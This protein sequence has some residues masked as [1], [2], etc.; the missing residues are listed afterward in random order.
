MASSRSLACLCLVFGLL[1]S[2]VSF[3]PILRHLHSPRPG[4]GYVA[5]AFP[6]TDGPPLVLT[7]ATLDGKHRYNMILGL[8]DRTY[9]P[10]T[11]ANVAIEVPPGE[12]CLAGWMTYG[13]SEKG[14]LQSPIPP[15]DALGRAFRVE[16]ATVVFL[17]NFLLVS[18]RTREKGRI[19]YEYAFT[20]RKVP[21]ERMRSD[22][23]QSYPG[24]ADL[25]FNC[26]F[27]DL[28][29]IPEL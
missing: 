17:G 4:V 28:K 2:C 3:H 19:Y 7:L 18:S 8:D 16:P 23:A 11:G 29:D 5:G 24:L 21:V 1:T 25:P 22:F 12:Y 9:D 26:L 20:P 10:R 13:G 27:C 6:R 15:E 14:I